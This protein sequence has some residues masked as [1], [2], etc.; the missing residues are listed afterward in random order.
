MKILLIEDNKDISNNISEVLQL[1]GYNITQVFDGKSGLLVAEERDFDLI[2]LD[3]W[4]PGIDGITICQKIR[5]KK[6]TPIIIITA[7][8]YDDD[9]IL[10][11]EVWADDY[12]VKPFK[13]KELEM[14]MKVIFKRL[15]IQDVLTIDDIEIDTKQKI[16]KKWG[17]P[18][19][20]KLKEYQLLEY[21]LKHKSAS[22]TDLID[23][24]WGSED[25]SFWDNNL[26]VYIYS[27]RTKLQ[28]D[29]IKTMKWY[30]Y[31]IKQ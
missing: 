13:I 20:L 21:L 28:K 2:I 3:L 29:I 30:G 5:E 27:L 9:K 19:A 23:Y 17:I 6:Q 1:D 24:L 10:W 15:W 26:D 25:I 22:R 14:R 8:W 11:L 16:V 18:I 4:L 12:I 31:S 7:R